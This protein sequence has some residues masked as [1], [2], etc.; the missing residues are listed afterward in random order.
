[1]TLSGIEKFN[2]NFTKTVRLMVPV[3]NAYRYMIVT[4]SSVDTI[5]LK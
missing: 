4:D 3:N 5:Q 2:G 1:M